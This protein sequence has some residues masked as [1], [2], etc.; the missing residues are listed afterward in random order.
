MSRTPRSAGQSTRG[1]RP[2]GQRPVWPAVAALL[3]I[4]VVVLVA[5]APAAADGP[6]FGDDGV[7]ITDNESWVGIEDD[8]VVAIEA[9]DVET[10]DGNATVTVDLAGWDGSA[11]DPDPGVA[12]HT[13]GV[14]IVG[15]VE[16]D[17]TETTFEL[18]DTS[19]TTIDL[20]VTV[21]FTLDHPT[22]SS[23][24]GASYEAAVEIIDSEGTATGAA[25]LTIKR[26][27]YAVDGEERFP[28]STE[29]AFSNQTVTATNLD[30][31]TT[32]QLYEFDPEDGSFG[33]FKT[34]PDRVND[35]TARIETAD[36]STETGWFLLRAD[37]GRI[38][39]RSENAF[40]LQPHELTTTAIDDTVDSTGDGAETEIEIDSPVRGTEFTVNVT[41]PELDAEALFDV[42]D[43]DGNDA[44]SRIDGS[45][46]AIGIAV[47]PGDTIPVAFDPVPAATYGFEFEATDTRATDN[48][49]I[50]VEERDVNAEFGSDV[51]ET[52]A[53]EIVEIDI[54]LEDT[55]DAYVMVGGDRGSE[56]RVLTNYFDILHV[57][58]DTTV[59][60]N[61][62][63]LGTNVPSKDVY[64]AEEGSVT[65]YLHAPDDEA[66]DDVQF[67]G[68]ADDIE[69]FRADLGIDDLPRPLQPDRYRLVAGLGG[70]VVVREDGV[71][72]FE[73]PLARSNLLLTDS[74]G[75]GNV[76][77]YVAPEGGANGIEDPDSVDDELIGTLTERRTVAKGDRL[78]FGIE[79]DGLTG[80]ISW[81]N[82][83]MGSDGVGTDP[84]TLSKLLEFPDGFRIDGRQTNPGA[85][86]RV[87]ELDI[88]GATDGELYL[89]PEPGDET[90]A[91]RY[92]ERYYLVIDTRGTGP[93]GREIAPGDE[94][95]FSFGYNSTGQPNW[96][97]TVDHDAVDPNGAAPHFPYYG[98]D[99]ENRTETRF[100]TIED[101]T[102]GYAPVDAEGRP[103]VRSSEN[104]TLSGTTNI[105]P[106]TDATI[107]LVAANRSQ[108][109]RITIEDVEIG[110]DGAFN[111]THDLSVLDTGEALEAEFYAEQQLV[112]K[113]A[114][115]IIGETDEIV[116][117]ELTDHT[118][119]ATVVSGATLERVSATIENR[120]VIA[121]RQVVELAIDGE[122]V[123]GRA[124]ELDPDENATVEFSHGTADVPPGEYN[125]TVSTNEDAASGRLLVEANETEPETDEPASDDGGDSPEQGDGPVDDAPDE[126]P[127]DPSDDALGA[128][129][130][131]PIGARHAIGGAAIVGAVHVLGSVA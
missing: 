41:S 62:R 113:R 1:G 96:F 38:A 83:R 17:G 49:A 110:S 29:F 119:N 69:E 93:F 90:D 84:A 18:N 100:V 54:A 107:Q 61:T 12:I 51:F 5:T 79:A 129:T 26:L 58:G 125:Y 55:D 35:T 10:A 126:D 47:D 89:V 108:P 115:T 128:V 106:G 73:R 25:E 30:P 95:R 24:D 16:T 67:A 8:H 94:Y 77:T 76:T 123:A 45:E 48:T 127:S 57:E 102:A 72:D 70:S 88:D 2:S 71:P 23:F 99:A 44:V 91:A 33:G 21:E 52:A 27:S 11:I 68:G 40:Q 28:P 43:G 46:D 92:N 105:A 98:P 66:F 65:S 13:D 116:H 103:I 7:T 14:E 86:E 59:R 124:V 87:T 19:E 78:V 53:G 104:A 6:A 3:V 22:D 36:L 97:D 64:D 9:S 120:G 121:D 112:D 31:A 130:A 109:T 50:S 85:N 20:E 63:L 75:F 82:A 101:P 37:D 114:A 4:C 74:G 117:Y 81:L 111:V 34:P 15:A 122:V 39:P 32:Y 118:E 56:D 131:A 60:I 80:V 42:F